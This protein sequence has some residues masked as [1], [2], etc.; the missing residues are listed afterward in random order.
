MKGRRGEGSEKGRLER[1]VQIGVWG[2]RDGGGELVL[3]WVS[4][5]IKKNKKDLTLF[6]R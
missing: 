6:F 2:G 4:S 3:Q 1:K 5:K